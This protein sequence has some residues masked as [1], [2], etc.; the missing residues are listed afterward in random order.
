MLHVIERTCDS[1]HDRAERRL[2]KNLAARNSFTD[3]AAE[4]FGRAFAKQPSVS[5]GKST[6]FPHSVIDQQ[7][8]DGGLVWVRLTER[9]TNHRQL[10]VLQ[11]A[12][13]A[14]TEVFVECVS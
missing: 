14:H 9:T 6:K 7:L 3:F 2:H 8:A 10:P 1:L 5:R 11:I 13:G 4:S 12:S